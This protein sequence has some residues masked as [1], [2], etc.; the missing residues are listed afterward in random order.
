MWEKTR[1]S[2][3]REMLVAIIFGG[4]ENITIRRRFNLAILWWKKVGGL[5]IFLFGDD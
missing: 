4:F 2:V 3:K 1:L 5:D